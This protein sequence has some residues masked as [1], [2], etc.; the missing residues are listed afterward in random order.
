[1]K[2]VS[3]MESGGGISCKVRPLFF[4]LTVDCGGDILCINYRGYYLDGETGLYGLN[5]RYYDPEICR[6][7]C[8]DGTEYF[9]FESNNGLNIY[10]YCGNNPIMCVEPNGNF[11]GSIGYH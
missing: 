8:P 6:S 9:D 11:I 3:R 2:R 10:V 7:I 4:V 5:A 1:M